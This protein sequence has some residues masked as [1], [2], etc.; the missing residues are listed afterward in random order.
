[1]QRDEEGRALAR[2]CETAPDRDEG[3]VRARHHHVDRK[4]GGE[5]VRH[6]LRQLE[7]DVLLENTPDA[8]GP[9]VTTA[10]TGVEHDQGVGC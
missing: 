10:V 9:R 6:D 2:E 8:R 1:M 3:V 4:A 7:D 5:P